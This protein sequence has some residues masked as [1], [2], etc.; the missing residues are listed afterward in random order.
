MVKTRQDPD[1]ASSKGTVLKKQEPAAWPPGFL[2]GS[3]P[4]VPFL[5]VERKYLIKGLRRIA[6]DILSFF[7]FYYVSHH[8][9]H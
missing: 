4:Y 5:S 8:I 6:T 7:P 3:L 2:L 9:V 1:L